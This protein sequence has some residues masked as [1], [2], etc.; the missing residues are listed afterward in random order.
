MR[1]GVLDEA[2]VMSTLNIGFG[3]VTILM[4]THNIGF[5]RELKDLECNNSLLS[6]A[7]CPYNKLYLFTY[8][9]F[10]IYFPWVFDRSP[11]VRAGG[12]A[13]TQVNKTTEVI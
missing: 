7:L 11:H 4:T 8:L 12:S 9:H 1:A 13:L 5:G 2:I 6:E 10:S 3:I